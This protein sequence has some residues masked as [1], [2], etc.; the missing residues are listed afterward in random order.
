MTTFEE[1]AAR[2]AAANQKTKLLVVVASIFGVLTWLSFA[3][4]NLKS[5]QDVDRILS[6][7]KVGG[8]F[9]MLAC[10]LYFLIYCFQHYR[11]TARALRIIALVLGAVTWVAPLGLVLFFLCKQ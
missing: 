11:E 2:K 8:P 9:I 4:E 3:L 10:S 5:Q 6:L 1:A 7:F